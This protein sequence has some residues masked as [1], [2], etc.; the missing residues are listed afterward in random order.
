MT[1]L[2][3][4]NAA[5]SPIQQH[6]VLVANDLQWIDGQ[7]ETLGNPHNYLNQDDLTHLS[8]SQARISPWSFAGLPASNAEEVVVARENVQLLALPGDSAQEQFREAPR[9]ETVILSLPLAIVRG[10]V[11]FLSEAQL[12]NFLDFWRGLFFPVT[13]AQIHFLATCSAALPAQSDLLY[14]NRTAVQSYVHG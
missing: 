11:P 3:D 4:P 10:A 14:V 6:R 13:N 5:D 7:L 2:A 1:L 12:H 9:S 8:V